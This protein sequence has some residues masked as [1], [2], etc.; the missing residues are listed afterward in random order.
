MNRFLLIVLCCCFFACVTEKQRLRICQTCSFSNT[1]KDSIRIVERIDS[2]YLPPIAGPVQYLEN[3]CK[4]LCDSLGRLKRFIF[5][6]KKN[7]IKSTVRSVGNSIAI[8]CETDSLKAQ[9]KT[10]EKYISDKNNSNVVKVLPCVNERTRF[11]GF[12]YWWFIIT[13]ILLIVK[14]GIRVVKVYGLKI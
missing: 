7:S 8:E 12:T 5:K 3:P 1:A 6:T 4:D 13:A 11:D 14:I 10:L 9:I 2:I